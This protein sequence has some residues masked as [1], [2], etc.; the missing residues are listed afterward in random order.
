M[1]ITRVKGNLQQ[2]PKGRE[3][4]CVLAIE[5][6]SLGAPDKS[7]SPSIEVSYEI[8]D[9]DD[10]PD[11]DYQV[12]HSGGRVAFVKSGGRYRTAR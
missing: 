1:S 7:L 8:A 12:T 4:Q 3:R 2:I 6:R 11:G 10:Y 5:R 9:Q